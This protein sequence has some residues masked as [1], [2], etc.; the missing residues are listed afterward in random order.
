MAEPAFESHAHTFNIVFGTETIECTSR[1]EAV[2]KAKSLS[3]E[4]SQKVSVERDDGAVLMQFSNGG[5]DSYV[6]ELRERRRD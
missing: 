3:R 1:E 5:L 4:H 6:Y 2:V